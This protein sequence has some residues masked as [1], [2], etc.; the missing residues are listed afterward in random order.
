M[1]RT[2]QCNHT[3]TQRWLGGECVREISSIDSTADRAYCNFRLWT[4]RARTA[5]TCFVA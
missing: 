3:E 2:Q 5:L 4:W 1:Q